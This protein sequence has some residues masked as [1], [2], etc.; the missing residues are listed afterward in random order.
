MGMRSQYGGN[1]FSVSRPPAV[2]P[3]D[4]STARLLDKIWNDYPQ[5]DDA[6]KRLPRNDETEARAFSQWADDDR[7]AE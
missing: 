5:L 7:G 6:G 2:A 1:S 3:I 4:G